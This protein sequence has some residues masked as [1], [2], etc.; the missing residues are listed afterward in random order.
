MDNVMLAMD[1][2]DTLRRKKR[3][4]DQELDVSGREQDLKQRLRKIYAAQGI[5]VT[6]AILEEGVAALK[7]DRFVYK[8]PE[9]SFAVKLARIYASR[10]VWGKWLLG[11]LAALAI[12][13]LAWQALVVAPRKA[14]PDKLETLHA[15]VVKLAIEDSADRQADSLLSTARQA[16][17]DDDTGRA[18]ALLGELEQMREQL[19]TSYRIR[20]VNRPGKR[21]GVWRVPDVNQSTRNFYIIVEAIAADGSNPRVP[22]RNEETGEMERVK[23]WGVRVDQRIFDRVAA[24]KQ[25]DGIVQQNIFGRKQPGRLEPEY[26][27]PT[28]GAA[29]T[30]W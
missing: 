8:P 12:G 15:E 29:I 10:G 23:T 5:E 16:L 1:V 3:L 4:V 13:V 17:R 9:D 20:I 22:I 25:D 2:V 14:L 30:S 26:D 18:R 6:D 24:D 27:V 7:E 21:S 19:E 11:T 28:T